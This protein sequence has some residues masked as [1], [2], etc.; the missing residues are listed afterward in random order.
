MGCPK[1]FSLLG[2]MGAA[3]LKNSERAQEILKILVDNLSIPVTCKIR[4]FDDIEKTYELVDKL[5]S[6]GISAIGIHGR[7]PDERPQHN[8]RNEYLKKIAERINIP[9]IANGGSKDIEKYKDI[10]K[11]KKSTGCTSVMIARA[12]QWN[13]SIFRKEGLLP[14]DDIIKAY[15]KYAVDY[16][17]P[18]ANAKYCV[19]NIIREL[20]ETPMGKV[21]LAAQTLEQ[22]W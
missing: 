14:I 8:N 21:F 16:N 4:I 1:K 10:D 2:G 12:A 19:Q 22:I 18:P 20:Q 6:T 9:V 13:C 17:N 5:V 11:F 3:L 15:L 7:T